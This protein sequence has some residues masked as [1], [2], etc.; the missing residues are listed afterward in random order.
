[1]R[2]PTNP[3]LDG[4]DPAGM[5]VSPITEWVSKTILWFGV[6]VTLLFAIEAALLYSVDRRETAERLHKALN[7]LAPTIGSAMA[8]GNVATLQLS[9]DQHLEAHALSRAAV[10]NPSDGRRAR[11]IVSAGRRLEKRVAAHDV[12]RAHFY[13]DGVGTDCG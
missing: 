6:F 12:A 10:Y 5:A 1:M 2:S 9:L 13:G 7:Q 11:E 8:A 3:W 4:H